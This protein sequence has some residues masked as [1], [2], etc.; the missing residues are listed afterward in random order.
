MH[1]KPLLIIPGRSEK[2]VITGEYDSIYR[3]AGYRPIVINQIV[4]QKE[5][6]ELIYPHYFDSN[7]KIICRSY[8]CFIL[9]KML[10]SCPP[11][12]GSIC[13]MNPCFGI[14][15]S[16]KDEGGMIWLREPGA[17]NLYEKI[18]SGEFPAPKQLFIHTYTDDW[19]A[20][21]KMCRR[22]DSY[23]KAYVLKEKKGSGHSFPKE[24]LLR[25]ILSFISV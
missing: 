10:S 13:M 14:G 16:H 3:S 7:S 25:L 15:K 4:R 5:L 19:Q 17:D 22:L 12:P 21:I 6:R 18:E 23:S 24:E 9:L 11:F 1:G 2:V 8:G 20:D